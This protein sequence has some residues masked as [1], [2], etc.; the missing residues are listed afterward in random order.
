[1]VGS[2]PS[3][4]EPRAA[5]SSV[6]PRPPPFRLQRS[7]C[8][9][10]LVLSQVSCAL[11]LNLPQHN[12]CFACACLAM[13]LG[14]VCPSVPRMLTASRSYSIMLGNKAQASTITQRP[15]KLQQLCESQVNKCQQPPTSIRLQNHARRRRSINHPQSWENNCESMSLHKL[16]RL[17]VSGYKRQTADE[18]RMRSTAAPA[19]LR[20]LDE[21]EWRSGVCR[22]S[23]L[24]TKWCLS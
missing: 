16:N 13:S 14:R 4:L 11:R 10:P 19:P 21:Q 3:L 17:R 15:P 5:F 9:R 23:V 24:H 8:P 18:V 22:P 2:W 20:P 6:P 7:R 12:L 1:M